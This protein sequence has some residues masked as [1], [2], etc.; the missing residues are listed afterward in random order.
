MDRTPETTL[1]EGHG[2]GHGP[3]SKPIGMGSASATVLFLHRRGN[4]GLVLPDFLKELYV[5]QRTGMLHV[6]RGEESFSFRFV[7][8]E[9]V[10]GSSSAERG[11]LGETMVRHGLLSEADLERALVIVAQQ[12]RRLAPV[13]RELEVVDAVRLEQAL[14][15]H[16]REMLLTPL[17]WEEALLLFEDQELPDVP[18]EDLTL[19]GSTG[20]L[21]LELVRRIPTSE[22]VR[23]GLEDIDQPLG[24]V[25]NPCFGVDRIAL[26]PAE[27]YLLRHADGSAS[28]RTILE[29]APLPVEELERSLLG[30]LCTGVVEY[31]PPAAQ[32]PPQV[33][34]PATAADEARR[35][36]PRL[37]P[38]AAAKETPGP[39]LSAGSAAPPRTSAMPHSV[40]EA[41][42]AAEAHLTGGRSREA[43]ALLES[44]LPVAGGP[45][46]PR[47]R[48][49]LGRGYLMNPEW[50]QKAEAEFLQVVRLDPADVK[51]HYALGRLYQRQG[52]DARARAMFQRVLDLRPGHEAALAEL[53]G[54]HR[55]EP[56]SRDFL[57]RL[58]RR[59]R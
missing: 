9:V 59:P 40:A 21:I 54:R 31:L 1:C 30:L 5:G 32:T 2:F 25:K 58:A 52:L 49:L 10:S 46:E 53:D 22:A 38:P 57:S 50:A 12:G 51:A 7:N 27:R 36:D 44:V 17:L 37:T 16:I 14:A 15:F 34:K 6:S 41:L 13:L 35:A 47:L 39:P 26:G 11:R 55:L 48:L 8:G 29:I 56:R 42:S 23:R 3:C 24:T 45:L 18:A 19:R 20:E 28:A 43:V 33:A 4:P